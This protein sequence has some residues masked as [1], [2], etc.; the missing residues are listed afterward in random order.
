MINRCID[1]TVVRFQS[2]SKAGLESRKNPVGIKFQHINWHVSIKQIDIW[3]WNLKNSP[4]QD[5][6][7]TRVYR[8]EATER[9]RYEFFQATN[10][11]SSIGHLFCGFLFCSRDNFFFSFNKLL[12]VYSFVS[13]SFSSFCAA[14]RKDSSRAVPRW[15]S[16]FTACLDLHPSRPRRWT[17]FSS[18]KCTFPPC[19]LGIPVSVAKPVQRRRLCT[20]SPS[21]TGHLW[22]INKSGDLERTAI[23]R[24]WYRHQ[25]LSERT[26]HHEMEQ[27]SR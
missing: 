22:R 3:T 11:I 25:E 24:E 1:F 13:V 17:C 6:T 27:V 2:P 23:N 16:H 19:P 14:S 21:S 5:K 7:K 15:L 26:H 10:W 9:I 4:D 20:K 18:R 8:K 12:V